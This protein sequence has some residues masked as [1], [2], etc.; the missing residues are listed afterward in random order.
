MYV[1]GLLVAFV[2]PPLGRATVLET[3]GFLSAG[4]ACERCFLFA[5]DFSVYLDGAQALANGQP[6][7]SQEGYIYPNVL[8]RLLMAPLAWFNGSEARLT[9]AHALVSLA[10]WPLVAVLA[11][12]SFR[13]RATRWIVAGA[14]FGL[15]AF[16]EAIELGNIDFEILLLLL[17]GF[18]LHRGGRDVAAGA[19]LGLAVAIKPTVLFVPWA[20][21]ASGLGSWRRGQPW[22][23]AARVVAA[24]AVVCAGLLAL[25]LRDN[26]S[27]VAGGALSEIGERCRGVGVGT[28]MRAAGASCAGAVRGSLVLGLACVGAWAYLRPRRDLAWAAAGV[29]QP[30][31]NALTS[32][33]LY[34]YALLAWVPALERL[35][36]VVDEREPGLPDVAPVMIVGAMLVGTSFTRIGLGSPLVGSV[37]A[38]VGVAVVA[39]TLRAPGSEAQLTVGM[40]RG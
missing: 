24:S 28:I 27:F 35:E 2:W 37:A 5:F 9:A 36:D 33:Y 13:R 10:L 12:M 26:L 38:V 19:L 15:W 34:A 40:R 8:A 29:A 6:A 30:I 31:A 14:V 21:A 25:D 32:A 23:D 11:A 1:V 17:A 22:A 7:F 4:G 20:I 16:R 3:L 39:A 18:R